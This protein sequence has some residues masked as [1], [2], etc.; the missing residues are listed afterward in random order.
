[1]SIYYAEGKEGRTMIIN[2]SYLC[3]VRL[4]SLQQLSK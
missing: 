3:L 4:L 2:C 1:M